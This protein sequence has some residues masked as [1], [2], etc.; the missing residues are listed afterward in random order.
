MFSWR[1]Y[2]HFITGRAPAEGISLC[3]R[4]GGEINGG[5]VKYRGAN[6]RFGFSSIFDELLWSCY[7]YE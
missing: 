1:I 7:P 5:V 6:R 3:V 2:A 4:L